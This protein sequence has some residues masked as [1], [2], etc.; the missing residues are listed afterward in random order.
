MLHYQQGFTQ[1]TDIQL[2]VSHA[3]LWSCSN[4]TAR[5]SRHQPVQINNHPTAEP[6]HKKAKFYID[7]ACPE[8]VVQSAASSA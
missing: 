3:H 2:P 8:A 7:I 1:V 4:P 6:F 5:S